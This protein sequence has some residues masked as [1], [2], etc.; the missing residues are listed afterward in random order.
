MRT[1]VSSFWKFCSQCKTEEAAESE[2]APVG[3]GESDT[4][5]TIPPRLVK[6]CHD[7]S[8]LKGTSIYL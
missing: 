6:S 7:L 5:S 4:G 1:I 8:A 3:D 2:A